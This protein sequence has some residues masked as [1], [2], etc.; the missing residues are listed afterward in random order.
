MRN[1]TFF[2]L[3]VFLL[4][5]TGL[6][7]RLFSIS[8]GQHGTLVAQA[9]EQ[10]NVERDVLPRRGN[11]WIQDAAAG[12][13]V[14]LAGSEVSYAVSATPRN[15]SKKAEYA[16]ALAGNL[17]V[18]GTQLLTTFQANGLYM[19]PLKHGLTKDAV[20]A[21]AMQ[22]NKVE[23]ATNPNYTLPKLDFDENQGGI[24][25]YPGGVFFIR[26]YGRV[27]PEGGLAGQLLGFVNDRGVGQYGF[28]GEYNKLLL[29]TPGKIQ[30]EQDSLGTLLHQTASI[31]SKDGTGYQ[32]SLDRNV[33]FEV[34]KDLTQEIKDSGATGGS[35]IVMD[36]KT[37]EIMAM[38]NTPTYSPEKFRDLARDQ[39]SLFDNQAISYIW[40]PGSIFKNIIMA[41]AL[42]E[43]LVRPETTDTFDE[44]VTVEGHKIETALRRAYGK[45]SMSQVLA[46]SDNVAM[47]WVANK[48]GNQKMHDYLDRFGFGHYSNI[49]LQNET[50]GNLLA[51]NKWHDIDRATISFGQGIAVSPLQVLS[52]YAAIANDGKR[53]TPRVVHATVGQDGQTTLVQP[54]FGEQV[55]KPE[56]AKELRN[57]MVYTV[58][59]AHNR[60]GTAGY[61]IGGKTGTAQIP[62]PVNGGYIADAYNHSFVGIGPSDNPR[63]VVLVKIDHPDLKKVGLYAEGTAVPLFGKISTFLLNYYQIHPTNK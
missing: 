58:E 44:S 18:D 15:V 40:E 52:A 25:Y 56:V 5:A 9:Q 11:V 14:L 24:L 54:E 41:S 13:P 39:T 10:Q 47:V 55:I 46:N 2:L 4:G 63:Y 36:P 6:V 49:D 33:Q 42:N 62:D 29:G 37:G 34:E 60:A 32:L 35:A 30:L 61:K 50:A 43:G 3:V 8:V 38:A 26:E 27:Y 17:G 20:D 45:E 19:A 57:M 28:E 1:R 59:F 23:Q 51:L 16:A 48:L 12:K 31:D 53:V 7:C 21:L 22:L